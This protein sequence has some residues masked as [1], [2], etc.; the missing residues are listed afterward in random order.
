M[1]LR[2]ITANSIQTSNVDEH[3]VNLSGNRSVGDLLVILSSFNDT[4]TETTPAGWTRLA[5][6]NDGRNMFGTV[7][8][9]IVDGTEAATL[10]ISSVNVTQSASICFR[11]AANEWI[12]TLAGVFV[13]TI[14]GGST[15]N[16][17]LNS[18]ATDAGAAELTR[19]VA[20]CAARQGD[21]TISSYPTDYTDNQTYNTNGTGSGGA[22][23]AIASREFS[24][25]SDDPDEFTLGSG[26]SFVTWTLAIRPAQVNGAPDLDTPQ[27][28][29]SAPA[30]HNG[31]I[32]DLSGNISDP[33]GDTLTYSIVSGAPAGVT[34]TTAGLLQGDGNITQGAAT[35]TYEADDGNGGTVQDTFVLTVTAPADTI[36]AVTTVRL[37]EAFTITTSGLT[38]LTTATTITATLGGIA[39]TGQANVTATTVDFNAPSE[40]LQLNAS[41]DL[42]VTIDSVPTAAS[43]ELFNVPTGKGLA[44][45]SSVDA[46]SWLNDPDYNANAGGDA[47]NIGPSDQIIYDLLSSPDGESVTIDSLGLI[48]IASADALMPT[49]T[50]DWFYLDAQDGYLAGPVQTL[51]IDVAPQRAVSIDSVTPAKTSVTVEFSYPDVDI[52]GYQYNIGGGWLSASSPLTIT[53]LTEDTAYTIQIRPINNTAIGQIASY[54]FQTLPANDAQPSPFTFAAQSD[55]ARTVYATSNTITVQGVDAGLDIPISVVDGEYSVST[56]G[57]ATWGAW[58]TTPTNV[59]L[60][61][62]VRARH[63]TASTYGTATSTTVTIGG[64]D[65][66][67]TS[68]TLADTVAPVITLT[69]GNVSIAQGSSWSEPGYSAIDNADGDISVTGVVVTGSVDTSIEGNYV[70]TYTATDAAGNSSSTTRTVTV[71]PFVPSDSEPP[72]I[73]LVGGN[74]TVGEGDVWVDPGYSAIDAVDGAVNVTVS[75]SV[76]TST[77]ANYTLTY[78]AQDAAGNVSSVTRIVT[79]QPAIQYPITTNA[80]DSRTV[81]AERVNRIELGEAVFVKQPT[82][83]LDYDFDLTEWLASQSDSLPDGN[84]SITAD[85]GLS[86]LGSGII[87]A[88]NRVK[89]WIG[90]GTAGLYGEAHTVELTI[91]TAGYRTAQFSFRL[92]VID[93]VSNG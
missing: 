40:G 8:G 84:F 19:F 32:V 30:N 82:E 89:V 74:V 47:N 92:V 7:Y 62:L 72:V 26:T 73:S 23:A 90:G 75:G 48:E 24:A 17:A 93:K 66:T 3:I 2:D 60:N 34:L 36:T 83:V 53:G 86:V 71:T 55:V 50:I 6:G 80:P 18:V 49:Q 14:N 29:I 52:T 11:I 87:P 76:D 10:T 68:T 4:I 38:D 28:D 57:G 9:R 61:Y 16:A 13:S 78:T 35:I 79:V 5:F 1:I 56:D 64:I 51:T 15:V 42:I 46:D 65:G 43:S 21:T 45:L 37:G 25:T 41:H 54:N 91:I 27:P 31:T 85:G 63:M 81:I 59:R 58:T 12:G 33:E 20:L 22:I 70:L 77:P 44:T 39:L 69:G 67:F 88:T